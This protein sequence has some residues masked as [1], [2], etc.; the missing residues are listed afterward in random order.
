MRLLTVA[1]SLA[2]EVLVTR[3]VVDAIGVREHLQFD[4]IG[5]VALK[6]FP[7]PVELFIARGR[8]PG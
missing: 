2:G 4:P 8:D 5:E 7:A 1:R 3:T 6:G